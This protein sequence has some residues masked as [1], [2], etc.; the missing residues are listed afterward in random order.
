M[1]SI[2][3]QRLH[4][5]RFKVYSDFSFDFSKFGPGCHSIRGVNMVTPR[6]GSNG[7]GKSTLWDALLFVLF[8]KTAKKLRSQ[9]VVPY[10]TQHN[11][12]VTLDLSI[13]GT[14][15]QIERRAWPHALMISSEGRIVSSSS[16]EHINQ[17]LGMDMDMFMHTVILAQGAPLFL[18][19]AP[20]EKLEL[21]SDVLNLTRFEMYAIAAKNR[22][23][24]IKLEDHTLQI[25]RSTV[26]GQLAEVERQLDSVQKQAREFVT[27]RNA[28][29]KVFK[30]R[31]TEAERHLG[32]VETKVMAAKIDR[33]AAYLEVSDASVAMTKAMASYQMGVQLRIKA[34]RM[35]V[36]S[37]CPQCGQPVS[38]EA[39]SCI[40]EEAER[41]VT[42][43]NYDTLAEVHGKLAASYREVAND[44]E[45]LLNDERSA[46][47]KLISLKTALAE[48]QGRVNPHEAQ[49]DAL[50]KRRAK[51]EERAAEI[52][53]RR[54]VLEA[55]RQTLD[56]WIDG[57]R[58][59]RLIVLEDVLASLSV[60][61]TSYA[62]ELGLPCD[63]RFSIDRTTKSGTTVS[64]IQ[65]TVDAVEKLEAW[66]G[67]EAQRLRLAASLALSSSLLVEAG[68]NFDLLALDEP[69]AHLSTEGLD[70][71]TTFLSLHAEAEG[72]R[73]FLTDQRHLAVDS[74]VT[75]TRAGSN[76]TLA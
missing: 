59:I 69:S 73:I 54:D 75:L 76:V 37:N 1:R 63:V 58:D 70:E 72:R 53:A 43:S 13:D 47:V 49:G 39:R 62:N 12:K 21:L 17:L 45:S 74:T 56:P 68:L 36:G 48:L 15:Y 42:E 31:V 14:P 38:K 6:L 3:F 65:M 10:G 33:D 60:L 22:V 24:T 27:E 61:T 52:D 55:E 41:L 64:G 30:A 71:L 44:C 5:E 57:F 28:A 19:L 35:T 51:L 34:G 16:Q 50:T 11:P 9:D 29:L 40:A 2:D 67:G 66:S 18:D 46:L 25:A 8:G 4:A 20:R 23:G 26:E 7:T 32:T